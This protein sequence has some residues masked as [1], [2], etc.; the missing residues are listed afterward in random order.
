[1]AGEEDLRARA[2]LAEMLMRISH[3]PY[4]ALSISETASAEQVRGA[5]LAL[6]KQFH[7]ARFGRTSPEIQKIANEV[8][9]GIKGAHDQ[10]VKTLGSSGRATP[11]SSNNPAPPAPTNFGAGTARGT[12]LLPKPGQSGAFPA[13]GGTGPHSAVSRPGTP[14]QAPRPATP[15]TTPSQGTQRPT[16]LGGTRAITSQPPQTQPLSRPPTPAAG[17]PQRAKSPTGG[18]TPT[19]A[20]PTSPAGI[21]RP[22]STTPPAASPPNERFGG[23]ASA[24]SSVQIPKQGGE[25]AELRNAHHLLSSR[26]W[27]AARQAF[28]ALAAKVPQSRPYRALL[29]YA[30]GREIQASGRVDDAVMEYQRA[31]QLDPDLQLAKDALRELGRKSRF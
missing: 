20:R 7:P 24:S 25:D 4:S 10:L 30:R 5:F 31:L 1:V 9:L 16:P 27:G 13:T 23:S 22:P 19:T 14:S 17:I 29:C 3:G 21:V 15:M 12:G 26:D 18:A 28:S 11:R 2:V 8:F 6:T